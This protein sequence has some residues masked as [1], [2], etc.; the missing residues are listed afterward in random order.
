M[1]E[2]RQGGSELDF[3]DAEQNLIYP[4]ATKGLLLGAHC[5]E[6]EVYSRS[7]V[8]PDAALS[9]RLLTRTKSQ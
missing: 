2:A 4:P 8:R 5:Y 6:N 3:A 7:V 1:V 9:T